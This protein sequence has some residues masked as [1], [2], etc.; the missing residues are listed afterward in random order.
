[1]PQS[2]HDIRKLLS[3]DF[4]ILDQFLIPYN[5][6]SMFLRSNS[7]RGGFELHFGQEFSADYYGC[8]EGDE[9]QGVMAFCWN[10]A[11][12]CQV[13]NPLHI[14]IIFKVIQNLELDFQMNLILGPSNQV[15]ILLSCLE[16]KHKDIRKHVSLDSL[17]TIY[18]LD[19]DKLVIPESLK[20]GKVFCRL[21]KLEDVPTLVAWREAYNLELGFPA[22][23]RE[24]E[25][26]ETISCIGVKTVFVLEDQGK[27]VARSD[28][29]AVL[30]DIVQIG[31]VWTPPDL[32]NQ[33]YARAVIAGSL[34]E[35]KKNGVQRAVL[36]TGNPAGVRCYE[37]LGFREKGKYHIL[38]FDG[39]CG[40]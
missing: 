5:D 30:S 31:G 24:Q 34:L 16:G 39:K 11:I 36:F 2:T 23:E 17:Q 26:A 6:T 35:A 27:L 22:L 32:R 4:E 15:Q 19:L 28:F 33:R 29:N 7:R 21:A 37:S 20:E 9:L 3:K 12:L 14:P 18:D 38:V 25:I 8:F 10:G 1:M 40:L 13:P